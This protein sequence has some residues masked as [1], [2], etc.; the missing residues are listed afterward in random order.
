MM[1]AIELLAIIARREDSGHQFKDNFSNINSLAAEMVAM[2][3]AQGGDILVGVTDNGNISGLS[4]S[5]ISRLNQ[6][7]SNAASQS[8]K[9]PINPVTENIQTDNG[10]VM[11]ISI[12]KGINKP[13]MDNQGKIWIKSG[14]DKRQVTA[15]E[16]MQR[17][18]QSACLVYADEL[19]VT[20]TSFADIEM[21]IFKAYYEN[22]FGQRIDEMEI[23]LSQLLSNLGLMSGEELNLTGVL[24]FANNPQRFKPAFEIKA[25][26][27][28]ENS[29]DINYYIDSENIRGTLAEMYRGASAFLHR[30]LRRIQGNQGVNELGKLEIPNIVLEELLVNALIHRDYFISAPIRLFVFSDRIELIS[31]GHLPNHLTIKQIRYGNSNMRNPRLASHASQILPYRGMGT[32]IPRVLKAYQDVEMQEDRDAN[33]FKVIVKRPVIAI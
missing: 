2:A 12:P 21:G 30:N 14:A 10:L 13:Y 9:P 7:V 32:G 1:E 29:I 22:R 20:G 4:A 3:N 8:V 11:A 6:L 28:P 16:E 19:P 26:V 5:D 17:M 25:I 18:F 24:L 33:Q 27:Y 23:N 31:P 15:R